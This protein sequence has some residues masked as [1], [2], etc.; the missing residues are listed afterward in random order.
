[1]KNSGNPYLPPHRSRHSCP[2]KTVNKLAGSTT[3][4][5]YGQINRLE[6]ATLTD[7]AIRTASRDLAR[8]VELGRLVPD[9]KTG[10]NAG[11]VLP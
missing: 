9:G 2:P 1:M 7:K 11:Y 3:L 10:N 5:T 4:P 8:L 6:T